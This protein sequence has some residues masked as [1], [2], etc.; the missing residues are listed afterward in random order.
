MKVAGDKAAGAV[1]TA[2]AVAHIAKCVS[3]VGG[4]FQ[5]VAITTRC[6]RMVSEASRGCQSLP[7]LH[8]ELVALLSCTSECA[9]VVDAEAGFISWYS[10]RD[11]RGLHVRGFLFKFRTMRFQ[12]MKVIRF[13]RKVCKIFTKTSST[14]TADGEF[15]VVEKIAAVCLQK[16]RPEMF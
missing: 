6:V 13:F 2:E 9:M 11:S 14:L 12:E 4:V 5:A 15:T 8:S 1:E 7:R 10:M 16:L 3:I